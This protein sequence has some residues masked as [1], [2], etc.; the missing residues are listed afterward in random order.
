MNAPP[1]IPITSPSPGCT[2]AHARIAAGD[3]HGALGLFGTAAREGDAEAQLEFGRM[4]LYGVACAPE[5]LQ[6]LSWMLR[7]A[8]AGHPAAAYQLA[9]IAAGGTLLAL[10]GD[11][12]ARLLDGVQRRFPPALRA[13]ALVFARKPQAAGQALANQ[14]LQAA[15]T[16]GDAVAALLLANRLEV[17]LGGAVDAAGARQLREQLTQAGV[18][19]LPRIS[20]TTAPPR[21]AVVPTPEDAAGTTLSMS[22]YLHVPAPTTLSLR[23]AVSRVAGVLNAAECGLVIAMAQPLLRPSRTVDPVSGEPLATQIRT[24]H[25]AQF[26]ALH[27]DL[28]IRLVQARLAE[29]AGLALDQ[30]ERLI[31]LRYESGQEYRPHRDYLTPAAIARDRPDAGDR[32]RSICVYLNDVEAGGGTR[33]PHADLVVEPKAGDAIVFDNLLEDGTPDHDSLH[34]GLPVE[35]GVKWLATLWFRQRP[36]RFF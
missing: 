19:A 14:L 35:R 11:A 13:A 34:A 27:E 8:S 36:Y 31:V 24:S 26:D 21:A 32:M 20:A 9:M 18:Q 1:E 30:A 4:L 7:A 28:A 23:P 15:A 3:A 33:F 29:A 5:P 12:D 16:R 10:D 25:D 2:E 22:E 6:A 17:G